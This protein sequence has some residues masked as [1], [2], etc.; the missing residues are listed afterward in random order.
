MVYIIVYRNKH[1][2]TDFNLLFLVVVITSF[3]IVDIGEKCTK[4]CIQTAGE[5]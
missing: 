1:H 3:D 5:G 2:L 4:F